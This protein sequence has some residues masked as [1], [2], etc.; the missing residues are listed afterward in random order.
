MEQIKTVM[1]EVVDSTSPTISEQEAIENASFGKYTYDPMSRMQQNMVNL[2][3]WQG[4]STSMNP[5]GFY[6]QQPMGYIGQS[7]MMG[8]GNN[9][10]IGMN[11]YIANMYVNQYG[12][13]P[14]MYN[15]PIYYQQ[16]QPQQPQSLQIAPLNYRGEFL[17]PLDYEEK[18]AKLS[19]EYWLKEQEEAV[20][21]SKNYN[22][23][24]YGYNYYGNYMYGGFYNPLRNEAN[25]IVLSMQQEARENRIQFNVN[26]GKLAMNLAYGKGNYDEEQLETIYRGKT[27]DNPFGVSVSYLNKQNRFANLV[28][29]DNSNLYQAFHNQISAQHNAIINP[30]SNLKEAFDHAGELWAMYELEEEQH[31]RRN[32]TNA[33]DSNGYKYF[34][35][36]TIAERANPNQGRFSGASSPIINNTIP[37]P[38]TGLN[39]LNIF[40]KNPRLQDSSHVVSTPSIDSKGNIDVTLSIPCNFGNQSGTNYVVNQNEAAYD[41]KREEFNR[42][43]DSIPRSIYT[44]S[45]GGG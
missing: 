20:K 14:Y 10:G 4:Y 43:I 17:P 15:N 35:R 6:Q 44:L 2:P 33:Y 8:N 29:F 37:A 25:S 9:Y 39:A 34:I 19:D 12:A 13:N 27:I 7:M 32:L 30:N 11:P 36:K 28:P 23:F 42:F 3:G 22:S 40:S 18:L 41:K 21:N 5:N 38:G 26:L 1:G 16:Q 45:P 31:R 24:G